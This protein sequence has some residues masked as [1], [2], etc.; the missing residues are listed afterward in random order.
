MS[1]YNRYPELIDNIPRY[2]YGNA[3]PARKGTPCRVLKRAV[4]GK[5]NA[6][7]VF[8]DGYEVV[9]P[10]RILRTEAK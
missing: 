7:V 2:Y 10:S 1:E 3:L 8:E 5:R 6:L 4:K 9:V